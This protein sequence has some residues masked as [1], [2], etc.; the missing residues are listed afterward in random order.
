MRNRKKKT[1]IEFFTLNISALPANHENEVFY[2]GLIE[3]F[4]NADLKINYGNDFYYQMLSLSKTKIGGK[5]SYYGVMAKFLQ[6]DSIDWVKSDEIKKIGK[7]SAFELPAGLEG[8]KGL[9]EFI[10]VPE[11]HKLAFIKKGKI[12]ESLKKKGA[13]LMAIKNILEIGLGQVIEDDKG[14][15]VDIVQTRHVIDKIFESNLLKLDLKLHYSNPSIHDDYEQFM[16]DLYRDTSA[17]EFDISMTSQKGKPISTKS[18]F[19]EGSLSLVR[20]NGSA[21]AV[22]EKD[23]VKEKINTLDHPEV[24]EIEIT[25]FPQNFFSKLISKVTVF[26]LN[27]GE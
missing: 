20:K 8:R 24:Q 10:F 16:D 14:I 1:S 22:I 13:S 9:Y 11:V 17:N 2:A 4:Y 25:D 7:K 15:H 27:D 12:D 23:G 6:L 26:L 19:V 5:E 18:K 3:S 21:K